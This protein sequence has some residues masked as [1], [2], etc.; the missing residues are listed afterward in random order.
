MVQ[1]WFEKF[2]AA[3]IDSALNGLRIFCSLKILSLSNNSTIYL[4]SWSDLSWFQQSFHLLSVI[5]SGINCWNYVG[6]ESMLE[7]MY[8]WS[9]SEKSLHDLLFVGNMQKKTD[10]FI[11]SKLWSDIVFQDWLFTRSLSP[12]EAGERIMSVGLITLLGLIISTNLCVNKFCMTL[13]IQICTKLQY[14]I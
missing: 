10:Y 12:L 1:A 3:W 2:K 6:K 11:Y 13:I 9:L 5:V 14:F 7:W 4:Q 8:P